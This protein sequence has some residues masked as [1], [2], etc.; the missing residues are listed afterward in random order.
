M[1]SILLSLVALLVVASMTSCGSDNE[2]DVRRNARESLGVENRE[3]SS[4]ATTPSSVPNIPPPPAPVSGTGDHYI[5][6]N[7]CEGSGGA[8]QEACPVCGTQY[9]HNQAFH[10]QSTTTTTTP[11]QVGAPATPPA[12]QNASGIYHYTCANGHE[13]GAGAAG[14]T[15]ATCGSPLTHNPAFHTN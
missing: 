8:T 1:K 6:P 2:S 7:N 12:A 15:C 10:A 4:A 11:A 9:V 14:S 13:G 5:C 3:A